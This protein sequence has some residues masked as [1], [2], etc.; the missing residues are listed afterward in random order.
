MKRRL[1]YGDQ[2]SI[3]CQVDK[4]PADLKNMWHHPMTVGCFRPCRSDVVTICLLP[5]L[6]TLGFNLRGLQVI[7]LDEAHE[8]GLNTDILFGVLKKLVRTR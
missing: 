6:R 7:V 3:F 5:L 4:G 2:E 8:R 1:W